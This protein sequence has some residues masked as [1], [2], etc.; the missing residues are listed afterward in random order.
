MKK[1]MLLIL[2]VTISLA[3]SGIAALAQHTHETPPPPPPSTVPK[4]PAMLD[5]KP[6]LTTPKPKP[7]MDLTAPGESDVKVEPKEGKTKSTP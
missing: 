4:S 3:L 6:E 1:L 2:A 7:P 5:S